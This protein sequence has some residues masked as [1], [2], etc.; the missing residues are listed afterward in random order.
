MRLPI[1]RLGRRH[2]VVVSY[3]A[4]FTALGGSAY[5]ANLVT[6]TDIADETI[7][8]QDIA[9][10]AVA[11]DELRDESVTQHKLHY[12]SVDG[13]KVINNSLSSPDVAN[14]GLYGYDPADGSVKAADL[15]LVT[16]QQESGSDPQMSKTVSATCPSGMRAIGG[17]GNIRASEWGAHPENRISLVQ[18]QPAGTSWTVRAEVIKHPSPSTSHSRRTRTGT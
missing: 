9:P 17:G 1:R 18:S 10:G 6:S 16:V 4:L 7:Q 13:S 8:A 11:N 12:N 15:G 2:S 14:G 5:A 3:V